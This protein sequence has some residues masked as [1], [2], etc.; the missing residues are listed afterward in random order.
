MNSGAVC[1]LTA[2][3]FGWADFVTGGRALERCWLKLTALGLAMQPMT[4]ITLF[5]LRWDMEG[6]QAFSPRHGKMLKALWPEFDA[7]FPAADFAREGQVMLFRIGYASPIRYGTYRKPVEHF[8][9]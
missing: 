7:L 8:L 4:A 2:P 5:R 3:G 6:E 1:L 9:M